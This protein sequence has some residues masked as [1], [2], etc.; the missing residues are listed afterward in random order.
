LS[1]FH[2]RKSVEQHPFV[3]KVPRLFNQGFGEREA[4]PSATAGWNDI[5]AFH[6]AVRI[7]HSSDRTAPDEGYPMH[8]QQETASRR[9][10]FIRE[11]FNLLREVLEAQVEI[12]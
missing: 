7:R 6:L 4:D 11:G 5:E 10:I 2:G 12:Q 1:P 8:S 3:S 9:A